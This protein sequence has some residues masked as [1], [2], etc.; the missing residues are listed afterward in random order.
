MIIKSFIAES[1]A[2]ALKQV[3][4]TMGGD[5]VILKTRQ[6]R[7]PRGAMQVEVTALLDRPTV[8]QTESIF[9][10]PRQDTPT[11]GVKSRQS[12]QPNTAKVI[13][14]SASAN[15]VKRILRD[16]DFSDAYADYLVKQV[17]R[18]G[19][20]LADSLVSLSECLIRETESFYISDLTLELGDKLMVV[21]PAG[22]GKTSALCKLAAHLIFQEKKKVRFLSLDNMKVGAADEIQTY[23]DLLGVD[24]VDTQGDLIIGDTASDCVTLVDTPALPTDENELS[25]LIDKATSLGLT[26]TVLCLSCLTRESDLFSQMERY[27]Q[28]SPQSVVMT[29]ADLS[30]RYG[31]VLSVLKQTSFPLMGVTDNSGGLGRLHLPPGL[32]LVDAMLK[33]EVYREPSQV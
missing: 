17:L 24:V 21:G 30:W 31:S 14:V 19:E 23:A 7:D 12:T 29:M 6:V 5:A 2:A 26:H 1:A 15:C 18:P 3:R 8:A 32:D 13:P 9:D 33:G 25:R 4:Q 16:A 22:S 27:K 11:D 28:F 10:E 20:E